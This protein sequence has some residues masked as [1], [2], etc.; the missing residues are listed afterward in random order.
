MK[1]QLFVLPLACLFL[2][3]LVGCRLSPAGQ[4]PKAPNPGT[5]DTT[6]QPQ[7]DIA[8][9]SPALSESTSLP[10][11]STL[12]QLAGNYKFTEGPAADANGN[13]YFSD[14]DAG[15][16]YKWMADGNV[17]VFVSGLSLPNGLM[18]D[19]NGN[20]IT[21]E[22]GKG[23]LVSID[24]QG[25]I[26]ILTDQYNGKRFNEP[27][28]LWID[29]TGGIYFTDPAYKSA[30]SQPG[31]YVYYLSPDRKTLTRVINDLIRPNGIIGTKDGK[32][33]YVADHG[34]GKT[35][36]YTINEDATLKDKRLFVASGSDGMELDSNG[37]LYLTLPNQ[38]KVY[39]ASGKHRLD[40]PTSENPTNIA[41]GGTD[42][43]ILFITART[44]VYTAQMSAGNS[45]SAGTFSLTSPDLLEG[46]RLPAEYTC[47]GVSSTLALAW[48]GAPE[49]TKSYAVIMHHVAGPQDV[50]WYWLVYD[51]PASVNSLP[52]NANG[53]GTLGTNSV[54]KRQEYTP[55]CSKGPGDKQYA[56]TVYALSAQPQFSV[57]ASSVN[58]DVL[59]D[60]IRDITLASAELQVVYARP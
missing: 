35:F 33:L 49:D 11:F 40:I 28:D 20:L 45:G 16:I 30:L 18:F 7:P 19:K 50:H 1:K 17:S 13:I 44:A 21:C 36:A 60:A 41:F 34:G 8:A 58:R 48:S 53:I 14:V 38:V 10:Q 43:R 42:A 23:R 29:P 5:Q 12:S 32:T 47:D 27:N 57:P 46:G 26:T 15:I 56:Y 55:P 2:L 24:T 54:N 3:T 51:I 9:V 39:E 37:N 31:E 6:P 25:Q 59:L 52:K 4:P 22:G